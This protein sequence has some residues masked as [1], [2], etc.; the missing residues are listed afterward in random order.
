M[1]LNAISFLLHVFCF[2][3]GLD[4]PAALIMWND[5]NLGN[6]LADINAAGA[7]F[8]EWLNGGVRPVSI[9][10]LK[11]SILRHVSTTARAGGVVGNCL[12]APNTIPQY[13]DIKTHLFALGILPIFRA[14]DPAHLPI[15]ANYII[16]DR[17]A[18]TTAT[19]DPVPA[20]PRGL[21][22]AVIR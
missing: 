9:A 12:I 19:A 15:G 10:T 20:P 6:A 16:A 7:A 17:E 1:F 8:P 4:D 13:A 18:Q 2:S 5:T 11:Q 22:L 3:V 14:I 21:G